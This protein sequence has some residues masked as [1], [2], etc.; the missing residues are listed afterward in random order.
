MYGILDSNPS[1]NLMNKSINVV[2]TNNIKIRYVPVAYN[3]TD[4]ELNTKGLII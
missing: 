3:V 2:I 1:N 4:S